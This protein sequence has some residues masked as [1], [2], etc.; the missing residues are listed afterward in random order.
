MELT[1]AGTVLKELQPVGKTH[2][3][4]V[5]EGLCPMGG[6]PRW[7]GGTAAGAAEME[8]CEQTTTPFTTAQWGRR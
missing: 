1:H 4:A 5:L 2:T 8:C 3:G 6:T 7:S